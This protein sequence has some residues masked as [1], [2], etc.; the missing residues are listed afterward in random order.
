MAKDMQ[1][2]TQKIAIVVQED[3]SAWQA[4]NTV[5]HVSGYL[6][7]KITAFLSDEN[8]V[9]KEG[10][11]HPRNSQY[12]IIILKNSQKG[13]RRFMQKVRASDLLY[14][15]FIREMIEM[16]DDAEI[17]SLLSSKNDMDIEYLGIGLFGPIEKINELTQGMSLWK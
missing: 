9:T 1:D 11:K 15:G 12:A 8:F 10:I 6:G 2:F 16:T 14:H 3:L 7:N 13:L 5:A 4:M 17:Q